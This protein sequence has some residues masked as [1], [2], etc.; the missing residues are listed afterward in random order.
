MGQSITTNDVLSYTPGIQT[1]IALL[2]SF[3]SF[4]RT[5]SVSVGQRLFWNLRKWT[6]EIHPDRSQDDN[7]QKASHVPR[8]SHSVTCMHLN[9]QGTNGGEL[10]V[11]GQEYCC[12][13]FTT[14][15]MPLQ[16]VRCL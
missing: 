12:Q 5:M 14:P 15:T 4:S 3:I 13:D 7:M 8:L 16:A 6:T 9:I 11:Q 1:F 2:L 10:E